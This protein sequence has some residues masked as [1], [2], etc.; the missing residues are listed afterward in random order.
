MPVQSLSD[1]SYIIYMSYFNPKPYQVVF[2]P[3]L[4]QAVFFFY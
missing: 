3:E 4:N 1:M 2:S